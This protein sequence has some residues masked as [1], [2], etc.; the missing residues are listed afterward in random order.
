MKQI[1]NY[2]SLTPVLVPLSII[3]V[4]LL[5]FFSFEF[6]NEFTFPIYTWFFLSALGVFVCVFHLKTPNPR[7]HIALVS[8][9][10]L[11][12]PLSGANTQHLFNNTID[13]NFITSTFI[14]V[15]TY[16]YLLFFL[17]S[18]LLY[19]FVLSIKHIVLQ[20][21]V[22]EVSIYLYSLFICIALKIP[23]LINSCFKRTKTSFINFK[24]FIQHEKQN[25]LQALIFTTLIFLFFS[26]LL[27]KLI[28]AINS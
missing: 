24:F 3:I 5:D 19:I 9:E 14:H 12:A 1:K 28:T 7:Y 16:S 23:S 2:L 13:P 21:K 20:A 11:S 26:F 22:I 8:L 10:L 18:L 27:Y 4:N 15:T 6:R 25:I 17:C